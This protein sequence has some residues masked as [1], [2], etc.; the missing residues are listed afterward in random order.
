MLMERAIVQHWQ[1]DNR[2][3]IW[4]TE[5]VPQL[6]SLNLPSEWKQNKQKSKLRS[7]HGSI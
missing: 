1:D 3:I 7:K 6:E 2:Q 4:E 5:T